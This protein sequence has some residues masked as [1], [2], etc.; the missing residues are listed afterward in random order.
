MPELPRDN[1]ELDPTL[2]APDPDDKPL[3]LTTSTDPP[4]D[5][6]PRELPALSTIAPPDADALLPTMM[7]TAPPRPCV[8]DPDCTLKL[9]LFPDALFPEA[10]DKRPL[11]PLSPTSLLAM[12][13]AP[14]D[15]L[16][17][18]PL[19]TDIDPPAEPAESARPPIT[20]TLLPPPEDEL[21]ALTITS[22]LRPSNALP[23]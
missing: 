15:A 3:P 1:T 4:T 17:L 20:M 18:E 13:T 10:K 21:P 22:P 14:D 11:A 23:V 16:I 2:T 7:L 6:L 19:R 9:P 12:V 5:A 8:A